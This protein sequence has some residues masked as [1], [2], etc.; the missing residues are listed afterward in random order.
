[1]KR[2]NKQ[3]SLNLYKQ[4]EPWKMGSAEKKVEW[5]TFSK[6]PKEIGEMEV[7]QE[8]MKNTI[9]VCQSR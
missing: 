8:D 1:M 6:H 5:N 9:N 2:S 4:I 7:P 3:R